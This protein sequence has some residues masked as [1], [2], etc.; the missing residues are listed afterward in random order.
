MREVGFKASLSSSK[1]VFFPLSWAV[2][3]QLNLLLVSF[4]RSWLQSQVRKKWFTVDEFTSQE[5]VSDL[6]NA[7]GALNCGNLKSHIQTDRKRQTETE[8]EKKTGKGRNIPTVHYFCNSNFLKIDCDVQFLRDF[9]HLK[10]YW[11][12]SFCKVKFLNTA[13]LLF[14]V[15]CFKLN[16]TEES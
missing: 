7:I 5:W 14:I 12:G 10:E 13:T 3:P 16:V 6:P 11:N 9:Q 15:H 2:F 8:T 4:S 1:S